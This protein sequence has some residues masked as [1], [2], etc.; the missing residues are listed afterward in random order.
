MPKL[1]YATCEPA[2]KKHSRYIARWK[3]LC[4]IEKHAPQV[5]DDLSNEP[6]KVWLASHDKPSLRFDP[7]Q[8]TINYHRLDGPN[9]NAISRKVEDCLKKHHILTPWMWNFAMITL[10]EWAWYKESRWPECTQQGKSPWYINAQLAQKAVDK[11]NLVFRFEYPC[12]DPTVFPYDNKKERRETIEKE[13]REAFESKMKEHLDSLANIPDGFVRIPR[14][15]SDRD[16]EWLALYVF[17]DDLKQED[18]AQQYGGEGGITTQAISKA[19]RKKARMIEL[20]LP[21]RRG[22]T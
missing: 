7:A 9:L 20:P 10:N 17:Y 18:I 12:P 2:D 11:D 15:D 5:L 16:F 14:M 13:M 3:F 4:A 22:K 19:I 6:L 1:V 21:D 8:E